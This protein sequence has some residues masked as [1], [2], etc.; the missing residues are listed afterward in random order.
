MKTSKVLS[1]VLAVVLLFACTSVA[2]S[3]EEPAPALSFE[4]SG[5]YALAGNVT[6]SPTLFSYDLQI[7]DSKICALDGES[8]AYT[9][10]MKSL[11][12][13]GID[14]MTDPDAFFE[15]FSA[16]DYEGTML[17]VVFVINFESDKV[18]GTLNYDCGITG[19][20]QP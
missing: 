3:A 7:D 10:E 17:E 12:A 5:S 2:V 4:V 20:M 16:E 8:K 19:F 6:V 13:N 9:Y 15:S 1:I 11:I 18:F 14:Y